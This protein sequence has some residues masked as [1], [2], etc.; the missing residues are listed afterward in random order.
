MSGV[1]RDRPT[2]DGRVVLDALVAQPGGPQLLALARDRD[3]VA[4][5]GGAV[6]DL[7]LGRVPRELDVLVAADAQELAHELAGMLGARVTA[8]GRFGTAAVEWEAGRVDVAQR[9]AE[10][11]AA[12]GALPDVRPGSAEQDLRRR[13]FTVNAIAAPLAPARQGELDAA[14]HALDDLAAGRL[15]VLHEHSFV[16]DPTRLLRLA[17]YCA[18]L[19]FEPEAR[20][21]ELA[22]AALAQGALATVTPARLG[23]ELR[24]ALCEADAPATLQRMQQLG[25]L[26]ALHRDLSFEPQLARRALELLPAD[27]RADLLLMAS[28]ATASAAADG[29][30]ATRLHE[31]LDT[32]RFTAI[33]RDRVLATVAGAPAL[34]DA[35]RG[36]ATPSQ[37]RRALAGGTLEAVALAAAQAAPPGAST[38]ARAERAL[39]TARSWLDELRHVR[40]TITGEDLLAAGV[41]EG[42]EVGA[43]LSAALDRKLDGALAGGRDAELDAALE[44]RV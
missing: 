3:D 21:G 6:R 23:T 4:V 40:L 18:R 36:P 31:L 41:P 34:G 32:L 37:L 28:L 44:A 5:V 35:L 2:R 17:R 12:P 43:R 8:H 24:L 11:Y 30:S 19:G 39:A 7:L 27:G 20:T 25:L 10:S 29:D 33:E 26:A 13:D 1:P 38:D 9:R 14:Q 22:R 15:R 16:D 42:P